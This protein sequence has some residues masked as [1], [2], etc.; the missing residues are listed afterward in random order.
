MAGGD[1]TPKGSPLKGLGGVEA[2]DGG[3]GGPLRRTR[4][5]LEAPPPPVSSS[6][7]LTTTSTRDVDTDAES[8]DAFELMDHTTK[9]S[10][11]ALQLDLRCV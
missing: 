9:K 1:V 11:G 6:S 5:F 8:L 4:S 7:V 10:A 2:I 3:K